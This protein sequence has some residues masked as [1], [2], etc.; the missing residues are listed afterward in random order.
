MY[1]LA[2]PEED[3]STYFGALGGKEW[4]NHEINF[5]CYTK[6]STVGKSKTVTHIMENMRDRL[7][8]HR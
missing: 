1:S 3:I 6:F 7:N 4:I 5:N 8:S 2:I